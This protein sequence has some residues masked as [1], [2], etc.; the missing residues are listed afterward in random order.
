MSVNSP[1]VYSFILTPVQ[2]T[3]GLIKLIVDSI[4]DV[5]MYFLT[6]T[7]CH[8]LSGLIAICLVLSYI[9]FLILYR[10]SPR[11]NITLSGKKRRKLLKQLKHMEAEKNK[12]EGKTRKM[13]HEI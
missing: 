1:E 5:R 4:L 6:C 7:H 3:G 13:P 9:C 2:M 12:M 11:A 10:T 8:I